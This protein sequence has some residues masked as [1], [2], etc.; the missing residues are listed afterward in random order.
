MYVAD[1]FLQE[2]LDEVIYM[3]LPQGYH[4]QGAHN[5][6]KLRKSLY[7][8]QQASGQ[9]NHKFAAVMTE[10]GYTQSHHDHSL[11]ISRTDRTTTLLVVY[12]DIIITGNNEDVIAALKSFLHSKLRFEILD[13]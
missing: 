1:V 6:C 11:F 2:D 10:A 3:Q 12:V 8:L 7:G 9:W 4:V 13:P 5:V